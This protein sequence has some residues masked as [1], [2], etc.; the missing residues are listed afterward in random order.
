MPDAPRAI[1]QEPQTMQ[2]EVTTHGSAAERSIAQEVAPP[3]PSAAQDGAPV[4]P[5]SQAPTSTES[6]SLMLRA[7]SYEDTR[8]GYYDDYEYPQI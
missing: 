2:S 6:G 7:Y 3:P 8:S 1:P 5:T 4:R